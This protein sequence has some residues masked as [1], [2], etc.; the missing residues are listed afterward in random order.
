MLISTPYYLVFLNGEE[1]VD[2]DAEKERLQQ[3]INKV[4]AD[5]QKIEN[6]LCNS[7]FVA[8]APAQVIEKYIKE[9]LEYKD[10]LAKLEDTR[11]KLN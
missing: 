9:V 7:G 8:K 10:T 2:L 4:K 1:I 11:Q 6:I 3:E 5:L